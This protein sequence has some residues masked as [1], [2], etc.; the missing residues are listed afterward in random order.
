MGK[1]KKNRKQQLREI[2]EQ[3]LRYQAK[4]P[5]RPFSLGRFLAAHGS[6]ITFICFIIAAFV[7]VYSLDHFKKNFQN[8]TALSSSI[9]QKQIS[10]LRQEYPQGFRVFV[11]SRQ[12]IVPLDVNTLPGELEINWEI[13]H[14][15]RLTRDEIRLQLGDISYQSKLVAPHLI[16]KLPRRQGKTY[17][18]AIIDNVEMTVELLGEYNTGIFFAFGFRKISE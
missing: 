7:L 16:I 3:R 13:S 14:L 5:Q 9:S 11:L 8:V 17:S 2:Q 6:E 12:M 1:H 10:D 15:V 4:I 18:I